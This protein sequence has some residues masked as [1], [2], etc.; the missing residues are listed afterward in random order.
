MRDNLIAAQRESDER[1]T[2]IEELEQE[3][4][5]LQSALVIARGGHDESLV[6]QLSNENNN[7]KREN[8]QL[9]HKIGLLLDQDDQPAFGRDRPLSGI[10]MSDRPVSNSSSEALAYGD[11]VSVGD[12]DNW[13][14]Q[15]S[16]TLSGRRPLSEFESEPYTHERTHSRS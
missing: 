6:E 8:E 2:R 11:R 9:S 7:L 1:L 5:R 3:V 4:E 10:S 15:F 16:S 12:F 13:Q 14:R